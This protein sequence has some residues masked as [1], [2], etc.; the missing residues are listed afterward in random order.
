MREADLMFR[1]AF[2]PAL[3]PEVNLRRLELLE[4]QMTKVL[5]WSEDLMDY[6]AQ[7][8]TLAGR[9]WDLKERQAIV[10]KFLLDP[11]KEDILITESAGMARKLRG[12]RPSVSPGAIPPDTGQGLIN[13]YFSPQP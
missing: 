12:N 3:P 9:K 10:R 13:K 4:S 8:G 6:Y 5:A 2:N 7:N 1:R 11:L